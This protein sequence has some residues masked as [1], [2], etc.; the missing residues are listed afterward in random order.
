M[1]E[2]AAIRA[3]KISTFLL[4]GACIL[5][6]TMT[7]VFQHSYRATVFPVDETT[8]GGFGDITPSGSVNTRIYVTGINTLSQVQNGWFTL[9][10]YVHVANNLTSTWDPWPNVSVAIM[11]NN[12]FIWQSTTPGSMVRTTTNGTGNFTL[13]YRVAFNHTIGRWNITAGLSPIPDYNYTYS[14]AFAGTTVY[15][16]NITANVLMPSILTYTPDVIFP[17]DTFAMHGRLVTEGLAPVPL[18][19]VR[20]SFN[21]TVNF[22][23][24]PTNGTGHFTITVNTPLNDPTYLLSLH[25]FKS[26]YYNANSASIPSFKFLTSVD[27][28]FVGDLLL[29]TA[30]N[31]RPVNT[32]LQI[33]GI[34]TYNATAYGA[35]DG[36]VKSRSVL[37]RWI[38]YTSVESLVG[39]V[40]TDMYGRYSYSHQ[41]SPSEPTAM[42]YT[43]GQVKISLAAFPSVNYTRSVY[44]RPSISTVI[45]NTTAPAW[46][47]EA[48]IIQGIL[49]EN[50]PSLNN[51]QPI[52]GFSVNISLWN[53]P[54]LLDSQVLIT[55]SS[56]RYTATFPAQNLDSLDYTVTFPSQNKYAASSFSGIF[57]V[58]KTAVFVYDPAMKRSEFQ[59]YSFTIYGRAYARGFGLPDRPI[60]SR[61]CEFLWDGGLIQ[62]LSTSSGGNF[63]FSYSTSFSTIPGNYTITLRLLGDFNYTGYSVSTDY[64][65]QILALLPL[66]IT[67]PASASDPVF[68]DE[69][70]IIE[71]SVDV[72]ISNM[73]IAV[74][75][76]YPGPTV[77]RY[78]RVMHDAATYGSIWT[79][80]MGRFFFRVPASYATSNLQRIWIVA[81]P[82][83][84]LTYQNASSSAIII[85]FITSASFDGILISGV[86]VASGPSVWQGS[87]TWIVGYVRSNAG[88]PVRYHDVRITNTASGETFNGQTDINGRFSIAV[89]ING[90]VNS[91]FSFIVAIDSGS[92]HFYSSVYQLLIILPPDYTWVLWFIPVIAAGVVVGVFF[93][94]K[95]SKK[96]ELLRIRSYMEQKLDLIRELVNTGKLKEAISYCYHVLVEVATRKF[97][98]DEVKESTTIREF[99]EMLITEKNV[100]PDIAFPFMTMVLEGLYSKIL[101]NIDQVSTV[102][103]LLGTLYANITSDTTQHFHL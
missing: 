50:E 60:S 89:R 102:V 45:I 15:N 9:R 22:T 99:I 93:Y 34:F 26:G 67:I 77:V 73:S 16:V 14:P 1:Q 74:D 31:P 47:D 38:T 32:T 42:N 11:M 71:G 98:L 54:T 70:L 61:S 10:G 76:E 56:G 86:P 29:N 90:T 63:Q 103:N 65:I 95:V 4:L 20:A 82:E 13:N 17:T 88:T 24:S 49:R 79:D 39:M 62:L 8:R 21:N 58:Y 83:H 36:Y 59:G 97:D 23:S 27:H 30:S 48:A 43:V 100:A 78:D 18:V 87:D 96:Q 85:Y 3:F 92:M 52:Q 53:G 51:M 5:A 94:I 28:A 55:D 33:Q 81:N 41:V 44:I 75:L 101:T 57:P 68:P 72:Q 12:S 80:K 91:N 64:T 37:V 19:T 46:K 40:S 7:A 35:G 69:P 6:M 84:A 2:A 66:A 25:F